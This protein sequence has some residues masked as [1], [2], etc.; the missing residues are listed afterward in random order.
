MVLTMAGNY[1]RAI[2]YLNEGYFQRQEGLTD[3][4]GYHV[5]AHLLRGMAY[6]TRDEISNALNDFLAA[7]QFPENHQI[8]KDPNYV[9]NP[10][11]NYLLG[12]VYRELGEDEKAESYFKAAIN[13]KIS[14]SVYRYYQ[15]MSFSEL[16][17]DKKAGEIFGE[18]I[19]LGQERLDQLSEVNFFAK[20]GSGS[21]KEQRQAAG[22]Y[23][24]A[25]GLMG[26]K[27]M[28]EA[29]TAFKNVLQLNPYHIWAR[30]YLTVL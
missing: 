2:D 25:L 26:K 24:I 22:H 30:Y 13:Q 6:L 3:L 19:D 29:K 16:G 5:D 4:H 9:R 12:M 8:G 20:F 28:S 23:M 18:L 7:Y 10:Q 21:T 11:I 17:N 1:D 15:G 27:K 14:P